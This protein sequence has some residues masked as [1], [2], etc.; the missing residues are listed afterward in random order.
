MVG[1][2]LLKTSLHFSNC[3]RAAKKYGPGDTELSPLLSPVE[4]SDSSDN[5]MSDDDFS[6]E[7]NDKDGKPI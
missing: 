2:S 5:D 4:E 3:R 7:E 1:C 6:E